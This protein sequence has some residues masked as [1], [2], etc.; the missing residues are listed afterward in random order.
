MSLPNGIF[1]L[2]V[3]LSGLAQNLS[4]QQ[5]RLN[6][7]YEER[8]AEF[9]PIFELARSLGYEDVA[10]TIAP[11]Q[12]VMEKAELQVDV[13]LSRSRE[14]EFAITVRPLN[15]GFTRKYKYSEFADN[16]LRLTLQSIPLAPGRPTKIPPA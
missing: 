5:L 9:R 3:F 7:E 12:V 2:G 11:A 15:L 1:E 13:R 4:H 10:R 6:E 14:Q 16:R 8:L